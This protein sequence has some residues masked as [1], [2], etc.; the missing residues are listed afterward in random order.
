MRI[1]KA[2]GFCQSFFST[3][4]LVAGY[5]EP[6]IRPQGLLQA[7]RIGKRRHGKRDG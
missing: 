7:A 3:W 2:P 6:D 4:L 5:G 1:F